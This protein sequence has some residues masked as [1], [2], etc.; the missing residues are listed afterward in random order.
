[1]CNFIS[2]V[3]QHEILDLYFASCL[4]LLKMKPQ[5]DEEMALLLEQWKQEKDLI[6]SHFRMKNPGEL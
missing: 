2:Q 6:D 3:E 1:M 4:E 5:N